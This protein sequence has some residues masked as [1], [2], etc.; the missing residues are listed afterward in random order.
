[1]QSTRSFCPEPDVALLLGSRRD[2]AVLRRADRWRVWL[3]GLAVSLTACSQS[4]EDPAKA[5][6]AE[7]AERID[8]ALAGAADFKADCTAERGDGGL[9]VRHPDGGFRRFA[10]GE[11]DNRIR[12][13]D[14][15]EAARWRELA[16]GRVE[17]VVGRD[18]YVLRL[19]AEPADAAS[20]AV[21][22]E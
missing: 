19:E 8:C 5:A 20:T 3:I 22:A 13:A 11:G 2:S 18:R 10:F 12:P 4:P 14:G 6:P 15:A 1:M 7:E 9:I 21:P 16:D 17:V